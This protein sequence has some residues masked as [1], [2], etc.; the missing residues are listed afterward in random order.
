MIQKVLTEKARRLDIPSSM[1][2]HSI[3]LNNVLDQCWQ[4]PKMRPSADQISASLSTLSKN[5]QT[6]DDF[7]EKWSRLNKELSLG[8]SS[9]MDTSMQ[10]DMQL[11][12]DRRPTLQLEEED[13][14]SK[15]TAKFGSS[16][17]SWLGLNHGQVMDSLTEEIT[18]A[19]QKLDEA[20]AHDASVPKSFKFGKDS[21]VSNPPKSIHKGTKNCF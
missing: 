6:T 19:I 15:I 2:L 14:D 3:A 11:D 1:T 8:D 7:D 17:P 21:F 13:L 10:F 9:P 18:D 12:Y 5:D 20:L 4:D 16:A